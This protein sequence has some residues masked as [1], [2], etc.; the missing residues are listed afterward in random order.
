MKKA[1]FG[2]IVNTKKQSTKDDNMVKMRENRTFKKKYA[3]I[4]TTR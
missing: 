4:G 3:K 1:V 2:E